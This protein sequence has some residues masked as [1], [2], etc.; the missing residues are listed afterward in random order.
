MLKHDPTPWL[1]S[2][3]GEAAVR[4]RRR[5]GRVRDDDE[6][7]VRS[8]AR[9]LAKAQRADGSFAGSPLKTAGAL[10]LLDDLR[11]ASAEQV[12]AAGA[13][14]L[15]GVLQ[16]Q[17]G[18]G[19]ARDVRP[20]GLGTACDLCGF[21]GPYDERNRPD[22]RS[23]GAAEMNHF[24][25]A[26]PLLGPKSPVRADRRGSRDRRGPGSCFEWGLLPLSYV[27]EAL[28]RA[29]FAGDAR[30]APAVNALLGAQRHSGGW[31]R[32]LGGHPNCSLYAIRALAAHPRLRTGKHAER[33]LT[34]MRASQRSMGTWW[35]GSKLFAALDAVS[36]FDL[37]LARDILRHGL[38]AAAPRQRANGSFGAPCPVERVAA[39]V[40]AARAIRRG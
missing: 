16:S 36:R 35:R 18:Y 33:A 20:G 9:R 23:W 25:R 37:P 5:L 7:P 21:F 24:R 8:T 30:L 40:S 13:E 29:G 3:D 2:Q 22:V 26:E 32:N 1:M 11:A 28:C 10:C 6:E 15:L 14:Y 12:A 31:C 39:A 19:R 17:R 27:I 38:A 34:M 4:A